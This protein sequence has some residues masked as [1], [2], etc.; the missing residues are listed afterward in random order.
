[1]ALPLSKP[2]TAASGA[3]SGRMA[4]MREL[5]GLEP[6]WRRAPAL[7]SEELRSP[8]R[9]KVELKLGRGDRFGIYL[10]S[11]KRG[12]AL[13]GHWFFQARSRSPRGSP[14]TDERRI[15]RRRALPAL[16]RLLA[17]SEAGWIDV[18]VV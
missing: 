9:R 17:D 10:E 16:K 6:D 8:A 1:M 15:I 13:G 12:A 18:I 11:A 2:E 7:P 3:R 14:R 5:K 4:V